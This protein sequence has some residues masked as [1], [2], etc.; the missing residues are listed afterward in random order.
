MNMVYG[1]KFTA[2]SRIAGTLLPLDRR[3]N[4][5]EK[6][7]YFAQNWIWKLS[8]VIVVLLSAS[9]R[10][11]RLAGK[12]DAKRRRIRPVGSMSAYVWRDNRPIA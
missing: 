4:G 3:L 9:A 8:N 7:E 2:S 6:M 12:V 10:W 11:F 1:V 5:E